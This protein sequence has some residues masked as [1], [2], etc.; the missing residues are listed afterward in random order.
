MAFRLEI[1]ISGL[2]VYFPDG[3]NSHVVLVKT[4]ASGP[5]QHTA[6]LQLT[7]GTPTPAFSSMVLNKHQITLFDGDTEI[8]PTL[9]NDPRVPNHVVCGYPNLTRVPGFPPVLLDGVHHTRPI[10]APCAARISL[11]GGELMHNEITA[12]VWQLINVRSGD[13][14]LG[15][16][17]RITKSFVYS[18]W[19]EKD[20]MK[21][22]LVSPSTTTE[23]RLTPDANGLVRLSLSN[24]DVTPVIIVPGRK[25]RS[26][27]FLH[28][29]DLFQP[30][31]ADK[32]VLE[33]RDP[34]P[35]IAPPGAQVPCVGG[36]T[37]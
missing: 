6:K 12:E 25:N 15:S 32:Y 3:K 1:T 31:G 26:E 34:H 19:I 14:A 9:P 20:W 37:C 28:V 7:T 29:Y 35:T 22:K 27:D 24:D 13:V 4:P 2:C 8:P 16:A 10:G 11:F 30:P 36:C 23:I 21:V 17:Q 33:E 18:R 5:M